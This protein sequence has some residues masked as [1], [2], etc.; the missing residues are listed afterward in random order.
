MT[1]TT[2]KSIGSP[3]EVS[4]ATEKTQFPG[5]SFEEQSYKSSIWL[6]EGWIRWAFTAV[7]VMALLYCTPEILTGLFYMGWFLLSCIFVPIVLLGKFIEFLFWICGHELNFWAKLVLYGGSTAIVFLFF[8]L[9]YQKT[10][11]SNTVT[12]KTGGCDNSSYVAHLLEQQAARDRV[13]QI[14][15]EQ[16]RLNRPSYIYNW[17]YHS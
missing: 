6:E 4:G 8:L 15:Y 7:G 16:D 9:G 14:E 2:V 13:R 11:E 1:D 12:P 5:P 10:P 17:F 3:E